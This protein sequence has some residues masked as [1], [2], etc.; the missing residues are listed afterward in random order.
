[1]ERKRT[2]MMQSVHLVTMQ[3]FNKAS[4][5]T[6][7]VRWYVYQDR[8]KQVEK[9]KLKLSVADDIVKQLCWGMEIP[10]QL[11]F[12]CS[13]KLLMNYWWTRF[14]FRCKQTV[15]LGATT[16]TESN[17]QQ[18]VSIC[19]IFIHQ[20]CSVQFMTPTNQLTPCESNGLVYK[21]HLRFLAWNK[22]VRLI[23]G[24]LQYATNNQPAQKVKLNYEIN[25]VKL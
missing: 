11:E 19:L 3:S 1:M 2:R 5:D 7:N 12:T 24:Y 9:S 21:L 23:H 17:D 4:L 25:A 16:F 14:G 22:K 18:Q 10:C 20:R 6:R 13:N 8:K 15:P